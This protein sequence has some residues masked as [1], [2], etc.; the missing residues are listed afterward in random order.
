MSVASIVLFDFGDVIA[1]WDAA[2]RLAEYARLSNLS[3]EAV[4]ERL[5]TDGF[6]LATDRGAFTGDEME[7]RINELLGCDLSRDELVR[8]QAHAFTVRPEMVRLAQ[9]VAASARVGI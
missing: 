1:T 9:E 5:A 7:R 3:P 4:E 6:W 8:L 2:A